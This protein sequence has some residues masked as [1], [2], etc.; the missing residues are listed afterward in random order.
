MKLRDLHYRRERNLGIITLNRPEVLNAVREE[1]WEDL[2]TVIKEVGEDDNV[3]CLV[4]T[5]EG[6]AFSA[7]QDIKEMGELMQ[8]DMDYYSLRQ[9]VEQIQF[10][11]KEI[12]HLSKPAI[13]AVNGYAIGAGAELSI[14]CDIRFASLKARFEFAEVKVGLFETNGVTYLLPKLIG[15]GRA[16]ELMLTGRPVDAEEAYRIGLVNRVFD[17]EAL[18]AETFNIAEEIAANAPVSLRYVKSCLNKSGE[19][20][21]EEAMTY[22]TDA[23]MTCSY[24]QD[25]REGGMAFLQKRKPNF[26]GR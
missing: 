10:V 3:R 6:K 9:Q 26:I 15:L 19:V 11:T 1:T 5:G 24:T 21:L 14:A 25:V 23:V 8:Q 13:A 16:K 7:G 12:M 2:L 17:P 20:S 18:L 4:I 22:E